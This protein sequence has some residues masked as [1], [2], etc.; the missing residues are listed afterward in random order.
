MTLEEVIHKIKSEN[1]MEQLDATAAARKM[2][3]REKCPPIE[4]LIKAG[5]IE[6]F[7]SFLRRVDW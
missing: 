5:V 7:I 3:S 4:P 6:P 2:L 1:V